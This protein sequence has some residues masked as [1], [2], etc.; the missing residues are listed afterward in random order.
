MVDI[1]FIRHAE[2]EMNLEFDTFIGGRSNHSP[3]TPKGI[4]QAHK[5]GLRLAQEG[6][7]FDK[8][9]SSIAKRTMQTA[10]Y[11]GK[12]AGFSLDDCAL[13]PQIQ[14]LDQG[15]W[16]GATR[17]Q[18]YTPDVLTTI[19]ANPLDFR[20]PNGESQRDVEERMHAWTTESILSTYHSDEKIGVITH[21]L[22]IKCFLRGMLNSSPEMTYKTHIDNT[23]IT[24]VRHSDRGW[25]LISVNDSSHL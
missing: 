4:S 9:Y 19:R 6:I 3:L 21:G 2:C 11:A 16:Q 25:D 10:E 20:A 15:D 14:E 17:D 22:A 8:V 23:S 18:T 1:Y 5:L 12:H 7:S 13:T 24:K